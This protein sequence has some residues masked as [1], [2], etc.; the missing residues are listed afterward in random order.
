MFNLVNQINSYI[1]VPTAIFISKMVARALF[2]ISDFKHMVAVPQFEDCRGFSNIF[3]AA[4]GKS[5]A[6]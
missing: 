2:L 5:V 3:A 1:L 4:F 6:I